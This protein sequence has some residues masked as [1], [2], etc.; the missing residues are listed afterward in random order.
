MD[1]RLHGDSMLLRSESSQALVEV[2]ISDTGCGIEVNRLQG[3][4][5]EL[6]Q[7][8]HLSSTDPE[9]GV[10][11][12]GLGLAVAARAISKMGGQLRVDSTPGLG[13]KF[14][15][16]IPFDS[17]EPSSTRPSLSGA[18]NEASDDG[19][20]AQAPLPAMVVNASADLISPLPA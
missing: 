16:L 4:F 15:C 13:S 18:V 7:V 9:Y 8:E 2:T 12:L 10:T 20:E 5:R 17:R 19:I 14:V 11:G 1:A 3:I 6:E